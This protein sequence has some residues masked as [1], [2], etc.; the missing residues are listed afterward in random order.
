MISVLFSLSA[1]AFDE[2]LLY[3]T[4]YCKVGG[5]TDHYEVKKDGTYIK[6]SEFYGKP[7]VGKGYWEVQGQVLYFARLE[8][9]AKGVT[10]ESN[11]IF[12][13]KIVKLSQEKLDLKHDGGLGNVV[14]TRC[15]RTKSFWPW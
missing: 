7:I 6:K 10:E 1:R 2:A 12:S 11:I 4:W 14:K 5:N 3:G 8:Y 9:I 15:S 13:R